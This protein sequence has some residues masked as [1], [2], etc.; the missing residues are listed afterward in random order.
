MGTFLLPFFCSLFVN[1]KLTIMDV[2]SGMRTRTSLPPQRERANQLHQYPIL[3]Q[4]FAN[5]F[6]TSSTKK[7][8]YALNRL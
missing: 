6:A 1:L 2:L 3:L 4:E 8:L 5:E 7:S